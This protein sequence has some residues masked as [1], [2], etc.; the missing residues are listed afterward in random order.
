M[1]LPLGKHRAEHLAH[2]C[3]KTES[4]NGGISAS[5]DDDKKSFLHIQGGSNDLTYHLLPDKINPP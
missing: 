5:L 1:D 3:H 2:S 4:V